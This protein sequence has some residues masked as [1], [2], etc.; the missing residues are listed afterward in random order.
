M[1]GRVIEIM[2]GLWLTISPF[3][4]GHYPGDRPLW[5]SDLTCGA[6]VVVLAL[7]SFWSLRVGRFLRYAHLL[8]LLVAFWLIGFGYIHGGYP[9]SP[10]YQNNIFVGLTL[11]LFAIIPNEASQPPPAWRRHY[12]RQAEL[13]RPHEGNRH[14]V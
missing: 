2:L 8:I 12:Q 1:W 3:L 10:G 6:A 5:T 9:S 4:F 7:L 13:Q 14:S 11:L